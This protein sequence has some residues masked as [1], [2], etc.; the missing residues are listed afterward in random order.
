[1]NRCNS[2][3]EGRGPLD[4][5]A[6]NSRTLYD[7]RGADVLPTDGDGPIVNMGLW[8]RA[9]GSAPAT[10]FEANL[11][12]FDH[13]IDRA[14]IRDDS[15]VLDVGCGFGTAALRI[16]RR[17][18]ARRVVGV[19][20]SSVQLALARSA[21]RAE[22][23]E[24]RVAFVEASA[25][26]LPFERASIDHVLSTEAAFHFADRARF[27][28]E[29][30]RVLRPNGSLVVADLVP[31]PAR[32]ELERRALAQIADALAFPSNNAQS[33]DEYRACVERAGLEL[34]SFERID[35]DVVGPFR[36]WMLRN[37]FRHKHAARDL[38]AWPYLVYPLQ[39]VLLRATR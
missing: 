25:L 34:R 11:A 8:R 12:L 10:L 18:R 13:C 14:E 33:L 28:R 21:A 1:M 5:H 29:V 6:T 23:L 22:A 26:S 16:A 27:F 32:N 38:R 36:R 7:D 30:A 20:V 15:T 37:A 9:D 39:Y 17:T 19:N 4:R 24:A 3:D 2:I 35:R 31:A